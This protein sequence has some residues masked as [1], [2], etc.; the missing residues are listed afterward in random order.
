MKKMKKKILLLI[1]LLGLISLPFGVYAK[2]KEYKTL[3]LKETLAEEDIE[4]AFKDYKPNSDAINIYMFRGKGCGYCHRFLEFLNSIT[5]EYGKYFN[6]VSYE[7]WHDSANSELMS[8]VSTYLGQPASGVPYIIIGDKVF[9][10]YSDTYNDSIKEAITAL[11]KTKKSKR[12]DV[13]KQMKKNPNNVEISDKLTLV[14]PLIYTIVATIIV[15][16][17]I[18]LK[19]KEIEQKID[20]L[21]NKKDYV[22]NVEK[23]NKKK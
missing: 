6:L 7:V 14:F 21:N 16:T 11:Y 2:E 4:E 18:N 13:F 8:N 20:L 12:Y 15:M 1:L 9:G 17:F 10:G 3:N 22:K 23:T 19:F 5:D